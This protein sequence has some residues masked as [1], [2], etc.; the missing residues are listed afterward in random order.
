MPAS[1]VIVRVATES[2]APGLGIKSTVNSSVYH[3]A[4]YIQSWAEI[5]SQL[6]VWDYTANC[7]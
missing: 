4:A 1:N 3:T 6:S 7:E 2:V 5:S